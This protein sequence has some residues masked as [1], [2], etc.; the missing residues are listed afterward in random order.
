MIAVVAAIVPVS[1]VWAA[2]TPAQDASGTEYAAQS[3]LASRTLLL[4]VAQAGTR[5]VAVGNYGH[6]IYS[7]DQGKSWTQAARVPTRVTLTSVTFV[8]DKV[9]FAGGHDSTVIRTEDGGVNWVKSFNDVNS[10]TPIMSVFFLSPEHGFAMGAFSFVIET[11]DGGKS[12][13]RRSL[14]EGD[15]DDYHLNQIFRAK[16]GALFV[17]AEFGIVY[18]SLDEGKTFTALRTPY[19]GSFWGGLALSDGA[20]LVFGMRGNAYR[21][22]NNGASWTKVETDTDAS[23]SGGASL[24]NDVVVLTGLQGFV[25]YSTDLAKSFQAVTRA[26]RLGYSAVAQ[27]PQGQIAIFGDDGAVLMPDTP[28]VARKAAGAAEPG[29]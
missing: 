22:N 8:S 18:R 21:S 28:A 27:G 10:E 2:S 24:A 11:R 7:D 3:K 25:G 5:L 9:G 16:S 20:V 26:D 1:A 13:T 14:S 15:Q 6:V 12:W 19:E 4:D 29:S 23:I 17:A